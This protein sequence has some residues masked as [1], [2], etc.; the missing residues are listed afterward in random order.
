MGVDYIF[1]LILANGGQGFLN[2]LLFVKLKPAKVTQKQKQRKETCDGRQYMSA[3]R[4]VVNPLERY[5]AGEVSIEEMLALYEAE[6]QRDI[7]RF[8]PIWIARLKRDRVRSR[9][10]IAR[11]S[12]HP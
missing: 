9:A 11:L 12:P 3:K 6:A 1:P 7:D 2:G 8:L 10:R 5:L 4:R